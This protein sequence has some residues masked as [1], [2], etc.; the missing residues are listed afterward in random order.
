VHDGTLLWKTTIDHT[1]C[2]KDDDR[3]AARAEQAFFDDQWKA[4]AIWRCKLR[5]VEL[6]V[7]KSLAGKRITGDLLFASGKIPT[8]PLQSTPAHSDGLHA[9]APERHEQVLTLLEGNTAARDLYLAVQ[10]EAMAN[11]WI[12][13][14]SDNSRMVIPAAWPFLERYKQ[15]QEQWNLWCSL[16]NNWLGYTSYSFATPVTDGTYVY[17]TTA[18]NVVAAVDYRGK[19]A[20]M[21]WECRRGRGAFGAQ[22]AGVMHTQYVPSPT[23]LDGKLVVNQMGLLRAY[24]AATGKKLWEVWGPSA[25]ADG[26][27]PDRYYY[28]GDPEASSPTAGY[29]PL[30]DGGRLAVVTDSGGH[31]WR[32]DDG[33]L[34]ARGVPEGRTVILHRESGIVVGSGTV[35]RLQ[36]KGREEVTVTPLWS[37]AFMKFCSQPMVGDHYVSLDTRA[38]GGKT[39]R[40][41]AFDVRTGA[42]SWTSKGDMCAYGD[43]YCSP[44]IA[45]GRLYAFRSSTGRGY[46]VA[47]SLSEVDN[48]VLTCAVADLETGAVSVL[49]SAA[50]DKRCLGDDEF[51]VLNKTVG[52][53]YQQNASPS[54]QGNRLFYRS[55]GT[56]WCIGD[57]KQPYDWNPASG[58][59]E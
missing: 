35:A 2:M 21:I 58:P 6:A 13:Q 54:A 48:G 34:L 15:A 1:L 55:R 37:G 20:W 41:A 29:L 28:R 17:V 19:V 5:K 44:I 14:R 3:T 30:P 47:T 51:A 38:A 49:P 18:N 7:A 33:K 8:L 23:L 39:N 12:M 22:T 9:P 27:I 11:G 32:L 31:L 56:L 46:K 43:E 24:D 40:A 25:V 10:E 45:G 4:Y 57:P 42:V 16:G 59:Q 36:A 53:G 26:K 50:I 52:W